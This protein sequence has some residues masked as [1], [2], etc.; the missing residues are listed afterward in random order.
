MT[1]EQL[2]AGKPGPSRKAIIG[3]TAAMLA[4][5]GLCWFIGAVVVPVWKVRRVVLKHY[6]GYYPSK[7]IEE[8]GGS[9]RAAQR[10]ALYLRAP[11]VLT[12]RRGF[13]A[14]MLAR[15]GEEAFPYLEAITWDADTVPY[16]VLHTFT[17]MDDHLDPRTIPVLVA[18]LGSEAWNVRVTAVHALGGIQDPRAAEALRAALESPY[19]DVRRAAAEALKSRKVEPKPEPVS[20]E[21]GPDGRPHGLTVYRYADGTKKAEVTYE[22]GRKHGRQVFWFKD[23]RKCRE[24][25]FAEGKASGTWTEWDADGKVI[26]RGTWRKGEPWEGT[27]YFAGEHAT[28]RNGKEVSREVEMPRYRQR[29]DLWTK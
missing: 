1:D 18:A 17:Q 22:D 26:V 7:G 4:A 9:K 14:V 2:E 29:V 21:V 15:C 20:H 19:A 28:Y 6:D 3:W 24:E 8:L 16:N 13:A 11:K 25:F 27:F 10:L 23:G 12:A 5:L